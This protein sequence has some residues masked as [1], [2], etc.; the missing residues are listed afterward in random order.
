MRTPRPLLAVTLPSSPPLRRLG[1]QALLAQPVQAKVQHS[2]VQAKPVVAV[3]SSA[4]PQAHGGP[5][6]AMAVAK[7]AASASAEAAEED[8]P[9]PD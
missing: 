9:D 4:P 6:Q 3:A 7:S 2:A 8:V 5:V 1:A